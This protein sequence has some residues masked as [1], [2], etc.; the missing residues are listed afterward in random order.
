LLPTI[1]KPG[2]EIWFTLN[3][4]LETDAVYQDFIVN[5]PKGSFVCKII[6]SA[7]TTG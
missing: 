7:I 6:V 4:D 5:P 3:P 2:S 1:R